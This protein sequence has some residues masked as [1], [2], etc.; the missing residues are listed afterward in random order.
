MNESYA[1]QIRELCKAIDI[2]GLSDADRELLKTQLDKLDRCMSLSVFGTD[3]RH[4][5]SVV[6]FVLGE[7]VIPTE[8]Q[9]GVPIQLQFAEQSG[10]LAKLNDG[11]TKSVSHSELPAVLDDARHITIGAP[12]AALRKISIIQYANDDAEALHVAAANSTAVTDVTFLCATGFGEQEDRFWR[13]LP[14]ST[15]DTGYLIIPI[16]TKLSKRP[17]QVLAGV[18]SVEVDI[19]SAL[20]EAPGD[21]DHDAFKA[22]GGKDL[23][24]TL[25]QELRMKDQAIFDAVSVIIQRGAA[26]IEP[27]PDPRNN[28][29]VTLASQS[30]EAIG[31]PL[32]PPVA[33]LRAAPSEEAPLFAD[34]ELTSKT[35]STDMDN[36]EPELATNLNADGDSYDQDAAR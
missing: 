28:D 30:G 15:R 18:V 16:G 21:L 12:L 22:C 17:S 11:E 34:G 24:L 6:N 26:Y 8:G 32:S 35:A 10:V 25:R 23:L 33:D 31:M 4:V 1:E 3:S 9:S 2:E 13:S 19:A 29:T 5:V 27:Q 7:E 20:R 14:Q 36:T